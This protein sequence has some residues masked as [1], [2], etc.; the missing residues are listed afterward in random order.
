[1]QRNRTRRDWLKGAAVAAALQTPAAAAAPA[2]RARR[3]LIETDVLVVGGGPAGIGAAL[4]AARAGARTLLI[5][6]CGFLGG[7]A[8]ISLGMPMNQVRPEGKPRSKVHELLIEKLL[9][10]GDQAVAFGDHQLY[11]NVD[12]LKVAIMDALD[13]AGCKYLVHLKAVD[14]LVEGNRVAGVAVATKEGI[15]NIPARIVVDCTGN[16]DVA[17]F[18]GAETLKDAASPSPI[19]LCLSFNNVTAEQLRKMKISEVVEKA[20]AKYPLVPRGWA[21]GPISNGHSFFINHSGTKELGRFDANDALQFSEVE[22]KSRR[23]ALQMVQAMREFGGEGLANVE[24]V[25]TG[26]QAGVR[27][28]RRIKGVYVLTEDDASNGRTFEDTIAWRSGNF[29]IGMVKVWKMKI[30]DVPYRAIL[31]EKL[32]GLLTAGRSVS[33]TDVAFNAGRSMGNCLATGHAAG[34]AAALAVKGNLMPRE[35]K[36]GKIQDTLRADGVDLTMGG[37]TQ[38]DISSDRKV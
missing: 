26:A 18:A 5:E 24:L 4:G 11:C 37:R 25:A 17:A 36:A 7:V 8:S 27:D 32:D 29:D 15:A 23:Q 2:P 33:S 12:Y 28:A 30:H 3:N 22:C 35:V 34:I 31:P 16:V 10:Y 38:K 14:A 20:R 21:L 9:A 19:T 13:A 1:M 6:N